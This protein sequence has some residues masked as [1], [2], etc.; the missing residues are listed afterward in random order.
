MAGVVP[1]PLTH[2]PG[3]HEQQEGQKANP[4]CDST[5]P[6]GS[7]AVVA[8]GEGLAALGVPALSVLPTNSPISL[9]PYK[10]L[11][12]PSSARITPPHPRHFQ[13]TLR[14]DCAPGSCRGLCLK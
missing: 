9:L 1:I 11:L 3:P 13:S 8:F 12:L 7:Q 4:A 14:A 2:N 5:W 6:W 10:A